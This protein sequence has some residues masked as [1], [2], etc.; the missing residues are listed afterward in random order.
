LVYNEAGSSDWK[1]DVMPLFDTWSIG[2]A[3]HIQALIFRG[4]CLNG[5]QLDN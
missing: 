2:E 3:R 1:L 4:K 5:D